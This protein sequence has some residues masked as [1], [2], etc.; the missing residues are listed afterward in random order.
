MTPLT[1]VLVTGGAGFIGSHVAAALVARGVQVTVLDNL[2]MGRRAAVPAAARFVHG[3]V[4]DRAAVT[5]A[6]AGV[7]GVIHLAAQVTIRGSFDRFYDDLD[8]NLMGTANVLRSLDP[9]QVRWFTLA[10]S[11]GV[12]ADAAAPTPIG[13]SHPTEPLSPYGVSKL[14][15][16]RVCR[17][18]LANAGVP[19]TVLRFFNTFGPGQSYTPYVGVITIFVTRLLRGEAPVVLGD[20]RQERDFVHVDDITDGVLASLG[21]AAG[22]FNLGSGRSTSLNALAALLAG[23]LAP[24]IAIAHEP[25]RGGELRF[26][27]ADISAARAAFGYAPRRALETHLDDVIADVRARPGKS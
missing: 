4:R 19:L 5:D 13:E 25:A 10:S 3:D 27:I 18:M 11:M 20:G 9:R 17:Q 16:E 12:Y 2:S 24:G 14:A 22:T 26:S 15:A 7:D 1:R 21:R 8:T 23:R 6:L